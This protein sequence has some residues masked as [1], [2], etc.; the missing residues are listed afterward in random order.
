MSEPTQPVA[1]GSRGSAFQALGWA[2]FLAGC[3]GVVV[4]VTSDASAVLV[5]LMVVLAVWGATLIIRGRRYST[6]VGEPTDDSRQPI[7][8]LRSFQDEADEASMTAFSRDAFTARQLAADIPHSGPLEQ[9]RRNP[10]RA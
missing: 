6:P 3:A 1:R 9:V 7:I 4:A 10:A 5:L 8:Y 2:M